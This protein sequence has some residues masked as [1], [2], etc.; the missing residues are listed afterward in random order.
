MMTETASV[1]P[2]ADIRP[3][4]QPALNNGLNRCNPGR[5]ISKNKSIIGKVTTAIGMIIK[6]KILQKTLTRSS[7]SVLE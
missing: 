5:N 1:T 3:Y 4:F 2:I 7:G 6:L